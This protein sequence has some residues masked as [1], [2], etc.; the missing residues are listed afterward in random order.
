VS[1]TV[2]KTESE[3][4]GPA[5]VASEVTQREALKVVWR[6][7]W[8]SRLI[9][10]AA[11]VYGTLQVGVAPGYLQYDR[12]NLTAPSSY[13]G[14]LLLGPFARWDSVWYLK[15]AAHGYQ[16]KPER[17]AFFP[18][19][20]TLIGL[21]HYV[22]RSYILS[23]ILISLISFAVA[24]YFLYKLT[25]IDF[26]REVAAVAVALLA[27]FPYS[28]FFSAVYTESLFLALT[29]AAV[30]FAR[31]GRWGIAAVIGA[32]GAATRNTGVLLLVPL[33]LMFLYGPRE[34][35]AMVSGW[36][37]DAGWRR[38]LPRYRPTR[39]LLWMLVVPLGLFAYL[40]YLWAATGSPFTTLHVQGFWNRSTVGPILGIIDGVVDAL[41]GVRQAIHG[42]GQLFIAPGGSTPLYNTA[43]DL[44]L[45]AF[46][47]LG[48]VSCIGA[49]R[50]LPVAYSMYALASLLVPLST[51]VLRVPFNSLPRFELV[52]FP[53]F[54]W[55]ADY[56]VRKR[57]VYI[58]IGMLASTLGLF[59]MMFATWHFIG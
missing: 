58:G 55:G 38:Y 57:A 17:T 33:I 29:V 5:P 37:G 24:L 59:T 41:D 11:G 28:L 36:V 52:M 19:Y 20:P 50:K 10:M 15:I 12:Y 45:F 9:V 8:T 3:P 40:G 44:M 53:L 51:P 49:I 54:I 46:F 30:Y 31:T 18:L 23:G 43:I 16:N 14:N 27:F 13:L 1:F 32:F 21:S 22:I 47:L 25:A 26:G 4:S 7:F 2:T 42:P 35:T 34:T 56:L 48:A 6:A 39:K